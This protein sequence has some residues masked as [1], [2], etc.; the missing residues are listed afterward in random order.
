MI[1]YSITLL[2]AGLGIITSEAYAKVLL[3]DSKQYAIMLLII[4]WGVVAY[5]FMIER[6]I[7]YQLQTIMAIGAIF[8]S[9]VYH[10]PVL[11]AVGW[12]YF[13]YLAGL[14]NGK[15]NREK[16]AIGM[17]AATLMIGSNFVFIPLQSKTCRVEGPGMAFKGV[18]WSLLAYLVM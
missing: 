2:L 3:E 9:T 18:A 5:I 7:E 17:S 12:L 8:Y 14:V 6:S 11:Y 1:S 16:M 10:I 13:G 15:V 4:F